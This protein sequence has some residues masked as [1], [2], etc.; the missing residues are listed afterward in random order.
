MGNK[1][2][3]YHKKK[4]RQGISNIDIVVKI[5]N[6]ISIIIHSLISLKKSLKTQTLTSIYKSLK[7]HFKNY[8]LHSTH[9]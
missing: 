8:N 7:I 1:I 3:A 2:S 9:D 4:I 6:K 5:P